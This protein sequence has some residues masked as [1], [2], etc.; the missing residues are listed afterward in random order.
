M[1]SRSK[2]E[3]CKSNRLIIRGKSK[4]LKISPDNK[5]RIAIVIFFSVKYL[6]IL[7]ILNIDLTP[8]CSGALAHF[9]LVENLLDKAPTLLKVER[10]KPLIISRELQLNCALVKMKFWHMLYFLYSHISS[11]YIFIHQY[12]LY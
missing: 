1:V 8:G 7:L 12:I 9:F 4:Y 10:G 3:N 6:Q 2:F 11:D 5:Q